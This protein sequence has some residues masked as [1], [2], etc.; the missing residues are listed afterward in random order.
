MTEIHDVLLTE[1]VP[2]PMN[3]RQEKDGPG[4]AELVESIK[5]KG[6]LEPIIVRKTRTSKGAAK[7]E[8]VAGERRFMASGQAGKTTIPVIVMELTDDEAYDV[9]LIENLQRKDLSPREEAETFKT[10]LAKHGKSGLPDLAQRTGV[11]PRYIRRHVQVLTLPPAVLKLWAKGDLKFGHLE[12]LLRLQSEKDVRAAVQSLSQSEYQG[13]GYGSVEELREHI[14]SRSVELK[15]GF[16]SQV[17]PKTS[18]RTCSKNSATQNALFAIDDGK[19]VFCMDP[20]CF[21]KKQNEALTKNWDKTPYHEKYKTTGFRFVD[22]VGYNDFNTFES[23]HTFKPGKKC[24]TCAN[25]VTI[26]EVAGDV[27]GNGRVCLDKKCFSSQKAAAEAKQQG[28]EKTAKKKVAADGPRVPWHG[29]YFRDLFYKA[30]IPE[31]MSVLSPMD[32]KVQRALLFSFARADNKAL[33]AV[34]VKYKLVKSEW[35]GYDKEMALAK[36]AML[37][38]EE[39]KDLF[40]PALVAAMLDG[41]SRWES[42]GYGTN[43]REAV[44]GFLGI[45]VAKEFAV[46]EAYVKAKTRAEILSFL[47]TSK[48]GSNAKFIAYMK[49]THD[50][51]DPAKIKKGELETAVL[52]CGVNLVGLV[53]EEILAKAKD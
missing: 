13:G 37:P 18:C 10:Y 21:K 36:V 52:K 44:A 40:G 49:K 46:D 5:Q 11:D 51:A 16:F 17:D 41:H 30:R 35:G 34:A 50:G 42:T 6:V 23:Y 33:D 24:E 28:K 48:I 7:Y 2:S 39:V 20:A 31:V 27:R 22:S 43:C 32:D 8:I 15:C 47:K 29:G 9:M 45:N 14:D 19:K 38:M 25:F 26:I 4:F 53:P 12:Q 3:P 1:L